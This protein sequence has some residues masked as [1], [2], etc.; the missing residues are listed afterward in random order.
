MYV[1]GK[2][3]SVSLLLA[4][5]RKDTKEANRDYLCAFVYQENNPIR[6]LLNDWTGWSPKAH[7]YCAPIPF[8]E[9]SAL[10][11]HTEPKFKTEVTSHRS[12]MR[13]LPVAG[14]QEEATPGI[15]WLTI[16][17]GGLQSREAS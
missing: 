16:G 14:K 6:N 3:S 9:S 7:F 12:Q 2:L 11:N 5:L 15:T 17:A 10:G 4:T 8:N 13:W 1:T